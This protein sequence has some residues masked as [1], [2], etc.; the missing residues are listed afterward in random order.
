[1]QFAKGEVIFDKYRVLF[2]IKDGRNA[3]TYRVLDDTGKL[4]CLKMFNPASIQ[5]NELDGDGARKNC[6]WSKKSARCTAVGWSN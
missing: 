5:S 3:E 2:P 6:L 1:M 4:C